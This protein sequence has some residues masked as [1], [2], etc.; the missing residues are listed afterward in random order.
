MQHMLMHEAST[1]S[2]EKGRFG[3]RVWIVSVSLRAEFRRRRRCVRARTRLRRSRR[4]REM[5]ERCS[6]T[7]FG[8]G[9][10]GGDGQRR[11]EPNN[12]THSDYRKSSISGLFGTEGVAR[13]TQRA[14]DSGSTMTKARWC[15]S[16]MCECP[17]L[18]VARPTR[19]DV[20][21]P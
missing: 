5:F 8:R 20:R 14:L 17:D 19:Y 9:A 11:F 2:G 12:A 7:F 18:A 15:N 13:A 6:K 3:R 10:A 16:P 4:R 1:R 21:R